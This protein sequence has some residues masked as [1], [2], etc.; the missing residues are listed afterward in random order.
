MMMQSNHLIGLGFGAALSGL[1]LV[2]GWRN[3]RAKTVASS[4]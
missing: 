2:I 4:I 3:G 1:V